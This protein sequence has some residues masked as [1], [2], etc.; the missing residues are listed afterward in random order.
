M[1]RLFL[2][3]INLGGN[4][5][6]NASIQ[7]LS[8]AQR[9][10]NPSVG[11]IYFDTTI[12]K[13]M[14]FDG[15]SW[16]QVGTD[17]SYTLSQDSTDG[18][19]ITLEDSKGVKQTITIPD[20]EGVTAVATGTTNG[21]I[22]VT[23]DGVTTQVKVKGLGNLAYK[24]NLSASDVGAIPTSQKGVAGGVAELD[25]NGL[26]SSSQLPSYV[27][28]VIEVVEFY[29]TWDSTGS[30]SGF[31]EGDLVY[32][33]GT[34]KLWRLKGSTWVDIGNPEKGKIYVKLSNNTTYRYSGTTLI[35]IS[36]AYIHRADEIFTG[37]GSTTEYNFK[38][39]LGNQYCMIQVVDLSTNEIVETDVTL[40]SPNGCDIIF[41]K[42]PESGKQYRIIAI[43]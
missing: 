41:A 14:I 27:D 30:T 22:A 28:D 17:I 32:S 6:L 34:N 40:T 19:I 25:S 11:Q 18:H 29:A 3:P 38:H 43:A 37:D 9:P 31:S 20:N 39:S 26:V 36:Q 8:T 10:S 24:N 5:L 33:V 2:V 21:T 12:K 4:E 23:V 35:E 16:Q 42:A 7:N 15:T 13:L 1:A